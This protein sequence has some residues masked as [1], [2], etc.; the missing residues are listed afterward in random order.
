LCGQIPSPKE[1]NEWLN[2]NFFAARL[3]GSGLTR[4]YNFDV[5]EI[6]NAL[7][8]EN[9]REI[10]KCNV[11]MAS[12]WI[13][14]NGLQ[15]YGEVRNTGLLKDEDEWPPAGWGYKGKIRFCQERW[16]FWK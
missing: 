16:Q 11:S 7:E 10:A 12:Q 14:R 8:N 13:H 2:L 3:K 1:F 5:Y 4:V 15:L 6:C 9:P